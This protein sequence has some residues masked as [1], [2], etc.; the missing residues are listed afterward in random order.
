MDESHLGADGSKDVVVPM[1]EVLEGIGNMAPLGV[2]PVTTS[3]EERGVDGP[4]SNFPR[5]I[6]ATTTTVLNNGQ[7]VR[8]LLESIIDWM[9]KRVWYTENYEYVFAPA[10][11]R[12]GGILIVWDSKRFR[13]LA[14]EMVSRYVVVEGTW[15]KYDWRCGVIGVYFSCVVEG[16]DRLWG[17]LGELLFR[18]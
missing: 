11:G 15:I 8:W 16:Q 9:V 3:P 6:M 12:D 2:L 10:E 13:L 7:G 4:K 14:K 17:V 1:N 5:T 18:H